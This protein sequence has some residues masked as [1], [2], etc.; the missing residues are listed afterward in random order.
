MPSKIT[1]QGQARFV[2]IGGFLGAGKTTVIAELVS[3]LKKRGKRCAIITNDQ[4]G[5]LVDSTLAVQQTSAVAEIAGGCFCCRLDELVAAVKKLSAEER[6]DVFLAEPVGSCTDLMA[7]VLLPLSKVYE[8][9][10]TLA[11]CLYCS[12]VDELIGHWSAVV[13]RQILA[14]TSRI[15]TANSSKKLR[16]WSST[17]AIY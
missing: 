9:P 11:P 3:W 14:K 8:M 1:P 13:A 16:S 10:L 15:F 5:H 4:G 12:M 2:L 7:T 6:P 17:R